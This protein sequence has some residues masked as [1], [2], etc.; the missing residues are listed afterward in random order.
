MSAPLPGLVLHK[1]GVT[2][3]IHEIMNGQVY[4]QRFPRGV[5]DQGWFDNLYRIPVAQ[6]D[7]ESVSATEEC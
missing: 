1:D 6:Y 5:T 7:V 4:F 2:V 3:H